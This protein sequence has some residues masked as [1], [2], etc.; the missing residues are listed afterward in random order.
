MFSSLVTTLLATL[1]LIV[2]AHVHQQPIECRAIDD[3]D[4]PIIETTVDVEPILAFADDEATQ[5]AV[6]TF[7]EKSKEDQILEL[8]QGLST[9][10]KTLKETVEHLEKGGKAAAAAATT[11]KPGAAATTHKAT[12]KPGAAATTHHGNDVTTKKPAA[13]T[14]KPGGAAT[15]AKPGAGGAATT[16]KP[17][18]AGHTNSSGTTQFMMVT[19]IGSML[20]QLF[21]R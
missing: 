12:A 16:K 2:I 9:E 13:T 15:T 4:K 17:A 14:A 18:T 1:A 8:I 5:P 20:M 7:A 10:M 19:L 3:P 11:A 21:L 6:G